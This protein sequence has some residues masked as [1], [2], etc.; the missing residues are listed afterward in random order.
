VAGQLLLLFRRCFRGGVVL[1]VAVPV[2]RAERCKTAAAP[3]P[4][5]LLEPERPLVEALDSN[6]C[7]FGRVLTDRLSKGARQHVGSFSDRYAYSSR[8]VER[9]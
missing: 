6:I 1:C 9:V 3:A 5:H 7:A 8:E 4:A 2:L